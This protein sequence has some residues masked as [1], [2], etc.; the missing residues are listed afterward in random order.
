[1][2]ECE[3]EK[4]G[5]YAGAVGYVS[6]GGVIDTAIAIRTMVVKDNKVY[7]QA[8]AGITYDSKRTDEYIETVNKLGGT[9]RALE[10]CIA[11]VSGRNE[12]EAKKQKPEE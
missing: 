6:F 10:Q 1:M 2:A 4:R 11:R 12:P 8:G 9:V 5:I 3:S 7:L